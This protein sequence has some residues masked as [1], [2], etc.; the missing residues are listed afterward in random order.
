MVCRV[1]GGGLHADAA[2]MVANGEASKQRWTDGLQGEIRVGMQFLR[3][4]EY[5]AKRI[6]IGSSINQSTD[7]KSSP[8]RSGREERRAVRDF[9]V[10]VVV[11]VVAILR[12]T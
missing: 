6:M 1:L 8:A 2:R 10:V 7:N 12:R 11:V 5:S 9:G 4:K 3:T